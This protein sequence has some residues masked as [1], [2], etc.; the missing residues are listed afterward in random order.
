MTLFNFPSNFV[1]W[2]KIEEHEELKDILLPKI[3]AD[4]PNI[5]YEGD[6]VCVTNYFEKNNIINNLDFSVYES[7]VWNPFKKCMMSLI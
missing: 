6:G 1:Y 5:K 3:Y 2:T 4:A 7:I